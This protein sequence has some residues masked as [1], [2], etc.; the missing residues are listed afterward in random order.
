MVTLVSFRQ[1]W[2]ENLAATNVKASSKVAD[3]A[4]GDSRFS[5]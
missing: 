3:E 1:A 2:Q 5:Y 4:S